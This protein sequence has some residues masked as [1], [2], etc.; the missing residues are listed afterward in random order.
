[1]L[2][3]WRGRGWLVPVIVLGAFALS[4]LASNAL[5]GDGFYA[6]N[7]WPKYAAIIFAALSIGLLGFNLNHK[8]RQTLVD[9]ETGEVQGKA[10]SHSLF[11]IPIEYWAVIIPALFFGIELTNL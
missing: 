5:Y 8:K 1:M 2:F 11:F 9:E 7:A 6:A 4:Q 10:P 3:I